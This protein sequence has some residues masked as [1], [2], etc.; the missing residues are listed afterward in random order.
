MMINSI[1]ARGTANSTW[2][3]LAGLAV[4]LAGF[5]VVS[6]QVGAVAVSVPEV[7][8]IMLHQVG[9]GADNFTLQQERV[10]LH[11]RLPRVV[12][13]MVVGAALGV[14]GASLQG[15]FRNPLVEPGLIG[16]S[17]GAALFAVVAIVFGTSIQG[18]WGAAFTSSFFLPVFSFV[19][20]LVA[21]MLTYTLGHRQ[22]K[23]DITILIL[24]GIAINALAGALVG[25]VLYFADDAALRSFTFWSMGDLGGAS[26][27]RMSIALP[28]VLLPTLALTLLRDQLNA[29]SLGE[30]EAY[31]LGVNVE[32][33]K[34]LVILLSSMAVGASVSLTGM[35]GFIGLVV[36][37]ILRLAF[38]PDHHVVLPGAM[39]TGAIVLLLAD[40]SART[41]VIPSELPIGIVTALLG[42][43][44]FIWLL[45]NAK[46]KRII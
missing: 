24:G 31:H 44:F 2:I 19:G 29:L 41:V 3:I 22:G 40:L 25:L 36:P 27:S 26:W 45:L 5:F 11:I 4:L 35:I 38:G 13:G 39:L 9:G 6:L 18:I 14:S 1:N 17:S 32:Q 43:P 46:K 12:L 10:L 7:L 21:T 23:T 42:A 20:G 16:V 30:A 8:S 28:M 15:L 33:V 37:H 34:Y